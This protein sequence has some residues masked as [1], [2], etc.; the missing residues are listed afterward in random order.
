MIGPGYVALLLL[1]CLQDCRSVHRRR[2]RV[3]DGF[4]RRGAAHRADAVHVP[5]HEV[6]PEPVAEAHRPLEVHAAPGLPVAEVRAAVAPHQPRLAGA[7]GAEHRDQACAAV[8]ARPEGGESEWD[9]VPQLQVTLSKLQH[10][11]VSAGVRIPVTQRA[12]RRPQALLYLLWDWFDGGFFE[13][14]R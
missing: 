14:W 9:V 6:A 1:G 10:V 2:R 12:E 5:L 3:V 11:M 4:A 8:E 13:R 7:A